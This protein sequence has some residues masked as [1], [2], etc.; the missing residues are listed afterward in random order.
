MIIVTG[1]AGF[2]GS[3]IV[4]GLNQRGIKD[5]IVVD[6]LTDGTKFA[7]LTDVEIADYLD[8]DHFLRLVEKRDSFGQDI[9]AIF[10]QGAC[11]TTTE[12]NGKY[13]MENNYEY[14][15]SLLHYCLDRGVNLMYASSAATYGDGLVFKEERQYEKP[16]NV[17]GYSK[18]LFDQYVRRILPQAKSQIAGF[19]YFNVYGPHEDHKGSMASV[20]YHLNQQL[21]KN[22]MVKLFEGCDGYGNGEQ[23]RDFVYVDDVVDV[24]L[25]FMDNPKISGIFNVG[26][27]K[28]QS[29]NDVAKA[30]VA[31]HQK[32]HI[33]Y[34]PF[35]EHLKGRYQSFTEA[36][37]TRLR[38]AGYTQAFKT[39]EEGVK[40]YLDCIK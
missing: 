24:N 35:P 34:I 17:Y 26:T 15:K 31:W 39:V 38:E 4:K 29:F 8:K 25:W 37:I 23:R 5:I 7:H 1:G 30:V 18:F 13:M 3:N 33:E 27:G 10:H 22:G 21:P 9:Q 16:L 20:A 19:R 14:S 28:S 6:E 32:G 11:S 2:I 40:L 12:W 36:D